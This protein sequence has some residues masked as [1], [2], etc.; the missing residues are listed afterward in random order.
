MKVIYPNNIFTLSADEEDAEY[1]VENLLDDHPTKIWKGT[2][3][4]AKL[5][6]AVSA[7]TGIGI[8]NTNAQTISILLKGGTAAI[9]NSADAAWQS[10]IAWAEHIEQVVTGKY[11]LTESGVGMLWAEYPEQEASHFIDIE[12]TAPDGEIIQAGVLR[13]GPVLSFRDPL[14]VKEGLKDY[15]I[16]DEF[17]N[18]AFY[19]LQR[20]IVRTFKFSIRVNRDDEFYTFM[21]TLIR[22]RGK[23]PLMWLVSSGIGTWGWVVYGRLTKLPEGGHDYKRHSIIS[24]EIIEVV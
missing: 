15:S 24:N 9:W 23:R 18:G 12:L 14:S 17:N 8:A 22:A 20:S 19:Y 11:D 10:G 7:G 6:L 3:K 13:A 1:P 2:S 21:H 4:D 5:S 16:E